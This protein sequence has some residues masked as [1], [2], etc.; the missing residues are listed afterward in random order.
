MTPVPPP[1]ART[2]PDRLLQLRM[3]LMALS[4]CLWALIVLLRLVQLQVL[5]RDSFARQ[6]ARQSERTINLD[7]RRGPILDRNGRPLA[8]S[9]DVESIY[10]VPQE[11]SDPQATA[12]ALARALGEGAAARR[13]LVLQLQK[14]RAFVW[15]KRKVDPQVARAVR[16]LGLDGIGFLTENRRYY[17]KRELAAHVLGYVGLDNTG[18]SGVEYAFERQLRGRAAKVVVRTDA[19]RRSLGPPDAPSTEGHAVVLTIDESIQHAAE[20]EL[21]RAMVETSSI[22]GVVVVSDPTTGE[23]LALANRPTFNPNRFGAYGS[24]RWRNRAVAD[25]YEPGSMFKIFT[26]A[27][28]LAQ[29]VVDPDEVIDCGNGFIEIAGTRINDHAVYDRL[30]FRQVI[31]KSSDIGAIRVAQRVGRE[32]F[33]RYLRDFGFGLPT[34]VDLPAESAGLLRPTARWSALS[35]PSLAFGQE[36][37]V[38]AIQMAVAVGAVANGGYVMRPLIVRQVEDGAGDVVKA[39]K[40]IA[41]RRVLEPET[42][43]TLTALLEGVVEGGTGKLAAIPGY[44]VAGKTGTAQK[45]EASG[46]YSATDHVASFVGFVPSRRPALVVL[47]SLDTPRGARNQGGD[48]AAPLFARITEPALRHLGIPPDDAT[49]VL[50]AHAA[51]EGLTPVAYQP[52]ADGAVDGE[53]SRMPDLMGQPAREAAI[54]AAR[55]GL[56]VELKGT[57]RVTAQAPQPGAAVEAG[58]TCVLSLGER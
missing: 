7:P 15:V 32:P 56:I 58:M 4:L 9:V 54:A 17:P 3:M 53:P 38:T 29:H 10:A 48:V 2:R 40:P 45:V 28:A 27:A 47:V 22:A 30:S 46:R 5:G 44:R 19:R 31:A 8:V 11:I 34:G 20:R 50:R 12:S 37:G 14:S 57:G 55:R 49:R 35:L 51:P 18:M 6:A 13:D 41:V 39:Y 52:A 23:I 33:N 24:A 21:E 16:A 25:A 26:A 1:F 43:S 42:T 36:I